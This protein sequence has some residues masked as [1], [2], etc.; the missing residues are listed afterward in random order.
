M[1]ERLAAATHYVIARHHPS[2]MGATKLNKVLWFADC[3]HY[4]RHGRTITG[5]AAYVRK[6]NGPCTAQFDATLGLLKERG[7]I[8]EESVP[9]YIG[10]PRR[11]FHSLVPPDVSLFSGEEIDILNEVAKE[12]ARL[13]AQ[14]ASDLSHDDLWTETPSNGLM[15][16]AAGAVKVGGLAADDM[17][18]AR[19]A[20]A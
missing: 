11:E 12:I 10:Y 1:N 2:H 8:C 15:P 13:T 6:P 14:E 20:F 5:E 19:A 3:E 17:D 16:V 9:T 18:W 7:A 4:R